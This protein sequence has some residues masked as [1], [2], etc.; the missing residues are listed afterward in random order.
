MEC[1]PADNA[2]QW[3]NGVII[4]SL[5]RRSD[6]VTSFW[7]NNDVFV[8][9]LSTSRHSLVFGRHVVIAKSATE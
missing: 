2:A 1:R 6:V 7:R 5:L 8:C 4:T 9:P 3:T